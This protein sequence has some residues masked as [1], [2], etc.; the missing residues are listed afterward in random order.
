V[1]FGQRGGMGQRF[2]RNPAPRSE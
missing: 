1:S 2:R